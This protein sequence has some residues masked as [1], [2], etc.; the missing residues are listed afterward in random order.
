MI[1]AHTTMSILEAS[2][3]EEVVGEF[4]SLKRR[5]SN[6]IGLC[7][8]HQEKTPSF[9]VSPSKGLF[10]CFG[11]GK[12]GD[13]ARFMMEHEHMTYPEALRYLAKKYQIEV[14]EYQQTPEEVAALNERERMFNLNTFAQNYFSTTLFETNEGRAVGLSYFKER[15]FREATIKKFQ[16]GYSPDNRDAFSAHARKNAYSPDI[17]LKTGLSVGSEEKLFDRFQARVIFPIHNLTGKV[18]GFGGR[19]LGSDKTKAK[20]LNSPESEIYNKSK[21]LYGIYFAKQ[22][23]SK[24]DNCL[25]VEGYTDVISMHQA[26]IE[27]VV[28]S[29]GTSLT[30]EQIRMIRRFTNN[31]TILYDGDKAGISASLRGTDMILEEG[32]NVRVLLFPDGDDPDSFVR[33]NRSSDVEAYITTK[34]T[35]FIS[36]KTAL[37]LE[38]SGNDPIKK[39]GLIKEIIHTISLIPDPI[40]RA[41]YIK[42]CSRMLDVE[43][44]TL[45]N[46]LNKLLRQKF[47]TRTAEPTAQELP[48]ETSPQ[49]PP[50][51]SGPESQTGYYQ[52][53]E[54]VKLLLQYGSKELV[55]EYT[56]EQGFPASMSET[57]ARYIIDD[58]LN[59]QLWFNFP[60]HRKIQE[61]YA[62]A[63]KEEVIPSEKFF[64]SHPDPALAQTSIDLITT[65]YRLDNW[66]SK[67]IFV[68][69]EEDVLKQVIS[70]TLLRFKDLVVEARLHEVLEKMKQTSDFDDQLALLLEKKKLDGLRQLIN[71]QLGITIIK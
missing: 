16:L 43:E 65:P 41:I 20:Y 3:I 57:A 35:D 66:E 17:L 56:D 13:S 62:E 14:E 48:E 39:A 58:L 68:K 22:A 9:T 69:T 53:R 2:R 24:L 6:L 46:E 29:S 34:A 50:K 70:E 12:G 7:P 47:K 18:I 63:L 30:T 44:Q 54:L 67:N 23:I 8:F 10:K 28:A 59:D 51:S 1:P 61:H 33:K 55:H 38:Q 11:C 40:Y 52:E 4:V 49:P 32:M 64:V 5:G 71:S 25:L 36:F 37:L 27:N 19:I 60:L 15:D 21:T 31:I 26:G 45:V 42:E